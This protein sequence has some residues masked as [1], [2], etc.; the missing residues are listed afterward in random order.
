MTSADNGLQFQLCPLSSLTPHEHY[1]E[2]EA[3]AIADD[4]IRNREIR[5]PLL[6]DLRRKIILD[7]HHRFAALK[8]ILELHQA[9]CYLIDYDGPDISVYSWREDI[10]VTKSVVIAAASS[11]KL[12]PEKTSRHELRLETRS[13]PTLLSL[14]R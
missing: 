12:L 8:D 5:D 13:R 11:G 10:A 3:R 6:I 7:G 9:P 14:L 2:Q 4:I 1:N